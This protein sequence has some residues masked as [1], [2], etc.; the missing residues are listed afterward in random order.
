[1]KT[2]LFCHFLN[3]EILLPSWLEHHKKLFS[4][5]VMLDWGSS[6]RSVEIIKEMCPTWEVIK[7]DKNENRSQACLWKIQEL[8]SEKQ[9][10][11]CALNV[12]EYL[13]IDDLE[14]YIINFE[15]SSPNSIGVK[16]TGIIIVDES[17]CHG[18]DEFKKKDMFY[19][20][21]Y[22]YLEAGKSWDTVFEHDDQGRFG[23]S[24]ATYRSRLLHKSIHGHYSFGRHDTHL[25]VSV[26]PEIFVSWIGRGSPELYVHRLKE[27]HKAEQDGTQRLHF[28][29][30][31]DKMDMGI[32]YYRKFWKFEYSKSTNLFENVKNYKTYLEKLYL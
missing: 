22:G 8:E 27:W 15:K 25:P 9:G 28:N 29:V 23:V 20:K 1:M 10:W 2:N 6:D 26:D 18:I 21:K 12:G 24:N 4:H 5:G 30:S 19:T 11:K 7:F 31:D 17:N 3:E 16:T 32:D 13:V 14:R